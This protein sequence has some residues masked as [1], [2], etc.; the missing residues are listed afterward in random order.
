MK[1]RTFVRRRCSE[2]RMN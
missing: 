1:D 2:V